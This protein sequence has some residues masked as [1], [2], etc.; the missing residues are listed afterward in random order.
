ME[1]QEEGWIKGRITDLEVE[2][3]QFIKQNRKQKIEN[4]SL[5]DLWDQIA[6][7]KIQSG[8]NKRKRYLETFHKLRKNQETRK[9]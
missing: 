1:I 2:A 3:K 9:K 6:R 8:Q 7:G 5:K 4:K